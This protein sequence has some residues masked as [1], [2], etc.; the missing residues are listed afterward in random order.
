LALGY[1]AGFAAQCV[2]LWLALARCGFCLSVELQ[3]RDP[4]LKD[5]AKLVLYPLAG[6]MLVSVETLIENFFAS[7]ILPGS[8]GL[9]MLHISSPI[10]F[11]AAWSRQQH[12]LVATIS[13]VWKNKRAVRNDTTP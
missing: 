8:F 1:L 6:Q 12:R 9:H 7:F 13:E 2:V 5:N 4:R 10:A 11:G 3:F